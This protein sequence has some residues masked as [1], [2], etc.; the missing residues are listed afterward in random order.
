MPLLPFVRFVNI[1]ARYIILVSL[2][3]KLASPN[4]EEGR[5]DKRNQS[6]VPFLAILFC[7]KNWL[8]HIWGISGACTVLLFVRHILYR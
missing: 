7:Q 3:G 2:N 4:W 1:I 5:K 6:L 8:R